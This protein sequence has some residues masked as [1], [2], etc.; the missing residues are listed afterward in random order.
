MW[1]Q[2]SRYL[3]TTALAFGAMVAQPAQAEEAQ[4]AAPEGDIVVTGFRASLQGA[5]DVKRSATI[6]QDSIVADD[7]AAF[8]DLNLAEA[9]QRLPGVAINREAG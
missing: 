4:A 1:T 8:P 2:R 7:I 6:I 9:L 3:M 5:R